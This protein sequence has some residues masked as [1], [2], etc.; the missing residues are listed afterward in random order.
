MVGPLPTSQDTKILPLSFPYNSG[1]NFV[2]NPLPKYEDILL[3]FSNLGHEVSD[4]IDDL[5]GE[6]INPG[7][8]SNAPSLMALARPA[9]FENGSVSSWATVHA[10]GYNSDSWS[11]LAQGL[12]CRFTI[13]GRNSSEWTINE[14]FY[15]G[16]L[17]GSTKE[18]RKAWKNGEITKT[19]SNLD[20][21][22]TESQ[23]NNHGIPGRE[24]T[25]PV[26]IQPYGPRYAVDVREKHISWMGFEFYLNAMQA[27]GL[28]LWDVKFKGERILYELGLQEAMAHYAG[29]DPMSIGMVW[30]DTLFGMGFNM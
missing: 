19:P 28:G 3:W 26:M 23:P 7:H 24:K 13:S 21:S 27:T 9:T 2:Q 1:R 25:T 4:I 12:Y 30:L 8:V 11:L 22:W 20:G 15:N 17:Y 16:I 29:N 10:P 6:S 14:W 5:I 18:F